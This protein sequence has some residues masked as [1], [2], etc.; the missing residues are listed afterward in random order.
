MVKR[1]CFL[2]WSLTYRGL[3]YFFLQFP[4]GINYLITYL[5]SLFCL[6][7]YG[8]PKVVWGVRGESNLNLMTILALPPNLQETQM[9]ARV[10]DTRD[11][12][13]ADCR[14]SIGQMTSVKRNIS[15]HVGG[16]KY[17]TALHDSSHSNVNFWAMPA[18]SAASCMR[19]LRLSQSSAITA[20]QCEPEG[21][22]EIQEREKYLFKYAR[23]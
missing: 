17:V 16:Q 21:P 18:S 20:L 8:P 15:C 4:S 12:Q 2:K 10:N 22:K 6:Y 7:H 9:E 5:V 13:S 11:T 3:P 19:N 14:N 23:C 1:T